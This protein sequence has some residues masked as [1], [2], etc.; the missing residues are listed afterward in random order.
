MNQ[1]KNNQNLTSSEG[2]ESKISERKSIKR[3]YEK[4]EKSI[5]PRAGSLQGKQ[6]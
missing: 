1:K 6:N 3:Y 5:K 4:I 2:R